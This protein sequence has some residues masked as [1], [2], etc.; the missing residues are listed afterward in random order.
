MTLPN[1]LL[2][3]QYLDL[4]IQIKINVYKIIKINVYRIG[5]FMLNLNDSPDSIS[6]S[7]QTFEERPHV[8]GNVVSKEDSKIVLVLK[9][10]SV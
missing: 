8:L 2:W 1:K 4:Q 9:E 5:T 10:M 6:F 3:H 7:Q